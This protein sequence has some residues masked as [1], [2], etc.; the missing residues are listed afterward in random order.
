MCIPGSS[1]HVFVHLWE[2][3]EV[4][5]APLD[6]WDLQ[7]RCLNLPV[8]GD[9]VQ[10]VELHS[11]L[12]LKRDTR[13]EKIRFLRVFRSV[14]T[15][16]FIRVSGSSQRMKSVT[17]NSLSLWMRGVKRKL[18]SSTENGG[19]QSCKGTSGLQYWNWRLIETFTSWNKKYLRGIKGHSN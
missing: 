7:G 16:N 9:S 5:D 8:P 19:C 2:A 6:V 10:V 18:S 12:R 14:C 3:E 11:R 13:T 17:S 15:N 1:C 4:E